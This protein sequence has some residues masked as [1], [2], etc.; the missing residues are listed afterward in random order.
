MKDPIVEEIHRIREQI[1]A[2]CDYDLDRIF[3][4]FRRT[5]DLRGFRVVTE[6]EIT[7]KYRD[8]KN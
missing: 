7:E 5:T 2:E 1:A 3:D 4:Y 8:S 6:K